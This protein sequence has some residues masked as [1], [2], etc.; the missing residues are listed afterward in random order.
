MPEVTNVTV[1]EQVLFNLTITEDDS[2]V[3][4]LTVTED[5][6][7][8]IINTSLLDVDAELVNVGSG[9]GVF[10]SQDSDT[11]FLRSFTDD[12]LTVEVAQDGDNEIKVKLP[13][14]GI[15]TPDDFTINANS[16]DS[17]N[18]KFVGSTV[19]LNKARLTTDLDSNSQNINNVAT[20]TATQGDI[21]TVNATTVNS[22]N[23]NSTNLDVDT[24]TIDDLT[25]V[26]AEASDK[27][28]GD[29]RGAV[30]FRAKA[31]EALSKGEAVYISGVSGNTAVVSLA[32]ADDAS[33]MPAY[34][35][36]FAD[37]N[38]NA[39]VEI[40][41][42]GNL[43]GLDTSTD[44]LELDKPVY[45]SPTTAGA[46]TATRPTGATH[47]VQNIGLVQRVHASAGIIRVGG[48]GRTNDV[49]N[50]FS[51]EGD[52]TTAADFQS[53]NAT[54]TNDLTV[55]QDVQI[56]STIS[57]F[58]NA[59]FNENVSQVTGKSATFPTLNSTTATIATAGITTG[60]ITTANVTD[61][62]VSNDVIVTGDLTVNGTTTTINTE[63]LDVADNNVVLNSNHTGTP[64]QNAGLTV[65]R[66]TSDDALFQWNESDDRWEVK[67]GT[68]YAE[69]K[70]SDLE[71][72]NLTATQGDFTTVNA[73]DLNTTGTITAPTID[74]VNSLTA[75][76]TIAAQTLTGTS[77]SSS[78]LDVGQGDFTVD[79]DGNLDGAC[80]TFDSLTAPTV[81]ADGIK[82]DLIEE[83]TSGGGIEIDVTGDIVLDSSGVADGGR[84]YGVLVDSIHYANDMIIVSDSE[85]S[86]LRTKYGALIDE[87]G[88]L[89]QTLWSDR[90]V[91]LATETGNVRIGS[92][93]Q[94]SSSPSLAAL[95]QSQANDAALEMAG[96]GPIT[97]FEAGVSEPDI[98]AS[99]SIDGTH[100]KISS[101]KGLEIDSEIKSHLIPDTALT[102]NLGSPLK[103]WASAYIG[104]G[105]LYIDGHKVLGSEATGQIDITTDDD[106]SLN[107]TAGAA[108]TTGVITISSAGNTT[109]VND[110]TINLGPANNTG[111][112]N[113][114][115]T[116]EAPDLH[117]GDLEIEATLINNTGTNANLEIRTDGTGYTHLNTADV[118]V[119]T[120]TNAMKIDETTLDL[121]GGTELTIKKD[122]KVEG[123][124]DIQDVIKVNDGFILEEFNPYGAGSN[125]PT[126]IMGVGQQ[127]GWAGVAI[128]NRGQHDFGLGGAY[129]LSPRALLSLQASLLDGSDNPIELTDDMEFG[130]IQAN[131]YSTYRGATA[132]MTP[133]AEIGFRTTESHGTGYGTKISLHS[134]AN[135]GKAGAT[136]TSH[137]TDT[138]DFQGTTITTTDKLVIDDDLEVTGTLQIDGSI[139]AT[140]NVVDFADTVKVTGSASTK[141]TSI[142]DT[143]IGP[144]AG[145][146]VKVDAGDTSWA[147]MLLKE[148]V[149]SSGKP[150]SSFTN[151]T[152]GTEVVGGTVASPSNVTSG[153]RI[154]V[155]QALAS[156][157]TD[158][159]IPSTSN[160]RLMAQT[161]ADQ[162]TSNRGTELLLETTADGD[163]ATTTTMKLQGNVVTLNTGGDATLET[164]G[165]LTINDD[166]EVTGALDVDGTATFDG[167]VTLGSANTDV[168]TCNAKLD[169][170]NGFNLPQ[171]NTATAQ[172]LDS[173]GVPGTADMAFISDGDSGS[174][175]LAV[176]SGGSWLRISLGSAISSS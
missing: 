68:G 129:N 138:I 92:S 119:G 38:N 173:I 122:L 101:T 120:L 98:D 118:Y 89:A 152:F 115:G 19:D 15:S 21:T 85:E 69:F 95:G 73:T 4:N 60:N 132:E 32:K 154:W 128:R 114:N 96:L 94:D 81:S 63:T 169:L 1:V 9:A 78:T 147:T 18:V 79:V 174:P 166:V 130:V 164:G 54:I 168:V 105:S 46:V 140:D 102:Y 64:T 111:T 108:G 97:W 163:T 83:L 145:H 121:I 53:L 51:I 117:V 22:T 58:G 50:T 66:G 31:G 72:T 62:N 146:G 29:I 67:V 104:S 55:N 144:Y 33:T 44:S 74:G 156:N 106:Q 135:G 110:T 80:A 165:D 37:A 8:I 61:L 170:Q 6:T 24:G 87:D 175:C 142:G 48:S 76:G 109:T 65:E 148:Y 103:P 59:T 137:F 160:F 162:T 126:T 131:P 139:S 86:S 28:I 88:I 23:V 35:L 149:G 39:N 172:Y 124:L 151:P 36:V 100:L 150:I 176:Y 2:T 159:T 42:F 47:L 167:N 34:G 77:L 26:T 84:P 70:T 161:T 49:P 91:N 25:V 141:T 52:I 14:V 17:A 41:E 10:K 7:P 75:S 153:K 171:M 107:I 40:V 123:Q 57:V 16:D 90:S 133:S 12:D 143:T 45:I 20:I 11:F 116:L 99:I 93:T 56:G 113:A 13:D 43:T 155:A 136:D 125:M 71:T 27:F 127:E 30:R 158:G 112:V 157:E 134:T 82:T 3:T 5:S